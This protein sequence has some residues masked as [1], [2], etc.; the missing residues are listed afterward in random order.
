LIIGRKGAK[1]VKREKEEQKKE[2]KGKNELNGEKSRKIQWTRKEVQ[3]KSGNERESH[4]SLQ[5]TNKALFSQEKIPPL[6]NFQKFC[7][8]TMLVNGSLTKWRNLCLRPNGS[9]LS[10][11]L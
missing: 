1:W 11:T 7:K 8:M 5:A 2:D 10:K 9:K 3:R 4:S 6:D